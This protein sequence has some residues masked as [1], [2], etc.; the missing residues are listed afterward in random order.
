MWA[1]KTTTPTPT[2]TTTTTTTAAA[3]RLFISIIFVIYSPLVVVVGLRCRCCRR[4][5]CYFSCCVVV[6]SNV[7]AR[8]WD[9]SVIRGYG[10]RLQV[11]SAYFTEF[12]YQE[13][14]SLSLY[15][16]FHPIFLWFSVFSLS[17]SLNIG[18]HNFCLISMC[19]GEIVFQSNKKACIR[20]AFIAEYSVCHCGVGF[21]LCECVTDRQQTHTI[22][23]PCSLLSF[24][25]L[26]FSL[27]RLHILESI[28]YF[29]V[30]KQN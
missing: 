21:G 4:R 9:T 7:Q 25:S 3:G 20:N 16:Y 10:Y 23:F 5:Y 29:N 2:T 13:R 22:S 30:H 11:L 12:N 1:T 18:Y 28:M 15:L 24:L 26:S 19:G 6:W 14:A 27:S 8:V 17:T